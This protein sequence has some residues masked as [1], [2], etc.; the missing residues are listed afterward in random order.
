MSLPAGTLLA[1]KGLKEGDLV[2]ARDPGGFWYDAKIIQK[3][4]AGKNAAGYSLGHA[5][6]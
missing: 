3:S 2:Q 4:G 5:Y 1:P 6:M